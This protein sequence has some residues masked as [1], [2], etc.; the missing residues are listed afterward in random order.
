MQLDSG[1]IW[2]FGQICFVDLGKPDRSTAL[3]LAV[4][5]SKG[6]R[7]DASGR[8]GGGRVQGGWRGGGA[9]AKGGRGPKGRT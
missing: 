1:L 9:G 3:L 6:G 7:G 4:E 2:V 5:T 8:H